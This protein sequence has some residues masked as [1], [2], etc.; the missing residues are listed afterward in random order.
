MS[1][2][3]FLFY[4]KRTEVD[5][6]NCD[7]ELWKWTQWIAKTFHRAFTAVDHDRIKSRLIYDKIYYTTLF[8]YSMTCSSV[9]LTKLLVRCS[10]A[11][12]K[13]FYADLSFVTFWKLIRSHAVT[14]RWL[15]NAKECIQ[16]AWSKQRDCC[17]MGCCRIHTDFEATMHVHVIGLFIVEKCDLIFQSWLWF[18]VSILTLEKKAKPAF[19]SNTI[20]RMAATLPPLLRRQRQRQR[21][22]YVRVQLLGEG[23]GIELGKTTWFPAIGID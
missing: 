12:W 15:D 20:V 23:T 14:P 17:S 19:T 5:T 22:E 18:I 4:W 21:S 11:P 10:K 1:L 16:S 13:S 9:K 3:T 2:E 7:N 8:W 6:M